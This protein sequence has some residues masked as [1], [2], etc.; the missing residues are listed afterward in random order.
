[1][2]YFSFYLILGGHVSHELGGSWRQMFARKAFESLHRSHVR[3]FSEQRVEKREGTRGWR[4]REC[5]RVRAREK[6]RERARE[7]LA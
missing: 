3:V 4:A 6:E 1:M 7:R 5:E 2:V